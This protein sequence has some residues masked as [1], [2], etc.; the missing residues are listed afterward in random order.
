MR[1]KYVICKICM[2]NL[3]F[4]CRINYFHI[5]F[6]SSWMCGKILSLEICVC[7]W[8]E[9]LTFN[10]LLHTKDVL[11]VIGLNDFV[12]QIIFLI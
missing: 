11:K 3:T 8:V 5:T 10:I 2:Q 9:F 6:S 7:V 1:V 12:H 4:L